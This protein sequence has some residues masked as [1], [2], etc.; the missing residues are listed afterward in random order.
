MVRDTLF[1]H[2]ETRCALRREERVIE[3]WRESS[4]LWASAASVHPSVC[5]P[6]SHSV[7]L[8]SVGWT[9]RVKAHF[10]CA[11]VFVSVYFSLTIL[12]NDC[13]LSSLTPL[14]LSIAPA[15]TFSVVETALFLSCPYCICM[16]AVHWDWVKSSAVPLSFVYCSCL[17][18]RR[19]PFSAKALGSL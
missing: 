2:Q 15:V 9:D 18:L 13:V 14:S 11:R 1:H 17:L 12:V 10:S 6:L 7:A 8:F 5:L 3:G 4:S 16:S 19:K